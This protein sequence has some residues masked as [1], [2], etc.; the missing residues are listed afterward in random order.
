MNRI[1][2]LFTFFCCLLCSAVRAQYAPQVGMSGTTAISASSNL[3]TGWATNCTI[4]RGYMDIAQP[5]LG[6]ASAGDS[7]LAIGMADD[8]TVS[9]GDSG[10]AVLTFASPIYNGDGADFAVFENG[11]ANPQNAEQAFL[12]LAFVEV[13]SDG[14]NYFRFPVSS[15]TQDTAQVVDPNDYMDCSLIN[16]LAGKYLAKY[17]TPFDLQEL[18]GIAGLDINNVTH[19]RIVDVIG[20]VNGHSTYD[21]A[22]RKINDP[23]P[24]PFATGGFDLDAVGVIHSVGGSA[25][26]ATIA[27]NIDVHAYPNPATDKLMLSLKSEDAV[28]ATFTDMT[29][30]VLLQQPLRQ[31]VNELSLLQYQSGIYCLLLSDTKGHRWAEKITK[32]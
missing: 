20:S 24:T 6:Y 31:G 10:V 30:K 2:I 32:L 13:S 29:G 5:S 19:V 14:A 27:D 1:A 26:V 7:S 3:F 4:Q 9:L 11:F 17:G 28:V 12:E 23:Y 25:G 16:N 8:Y 18:S 22:G 21:T 15:L